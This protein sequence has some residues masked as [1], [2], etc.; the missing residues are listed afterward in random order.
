[1]TP[2][3]SSSLLLAFNKTPI[4]HYG[5]SIL[6]YYFSLEHESEDRI[7]NSCFSFLSSNSTSS[8]SIHDDDNK[9]ITLYTLSNL[10][11]SVDRQ[12]IVENIMTIVNPNK[13]HTYTKDHITI[14]MT[15]ILNIC[16]FTNTHMTLFSHD[17]LVGI[18]NTTIAATTTD[19]TTTTTTN[20]YYYHSYLIIPITSINGIYSICC[21]TSRL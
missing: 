10:L 14:L 20:Y 8:N 5:A 9:I 12:R 17:I 21:C 1:L 15:A 7:Y 13:C 19:T 4:A 3:L 11:P 2:S 16:S 18:Y 6:Y